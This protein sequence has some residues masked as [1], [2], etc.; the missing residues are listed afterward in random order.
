MAFCRAYEAARKRHLKEVEACDG[1]ANFIPALPVVS[2]AAPVHGRRNNTV[3]HQRRCLRYG[4]TGG[5]CAP[6]RAGRAYPA[7]SIFWHAAGSS[8]VPAEDDVF[9]I[10]EELGITSGRNVSP[11]ATSA[12]VDTIKVL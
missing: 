7:D 10:C 6:S 3:S 5:S 2:P 1:D 8:V 12:L 9:V 4:H 11:C